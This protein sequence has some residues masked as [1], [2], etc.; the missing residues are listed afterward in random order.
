[1]F[2]LEGVFGA[3]DLALEVGCEGGVVVGQ[4]LDLEVAAE[5]GLGHVDVLQLHFHLVHLPIRLLRASERGPRSQAR[6]ARVGQAPCLR[7]RRAQRACNVAI[8]SFSSSSNRNARWR[9]RRGDAVRQAL[10]RLAGCV[11]IRADGRGYISRRTIHADIDR[12][13]PLLF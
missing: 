12:S 8:S 4:A 13:R 3:D 6:R 5:E 1:M 2:S 11:F 10:I 9:R 7:P